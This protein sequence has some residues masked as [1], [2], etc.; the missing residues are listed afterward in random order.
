METGEGMAKRRHRDDWVSLLLLLV[1]IFIDLADLLPFN[2]PVSTIE[3]LF[4]IYVGVR[5]A[6]SVAVAIIN[7]IPVINLFPWSTLAVLHMRY[8]VSL[9]WLSGLFRDEQ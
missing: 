1:A 5:P 8:G 7:L 2:L 3:A 9:G 6:T 4:L